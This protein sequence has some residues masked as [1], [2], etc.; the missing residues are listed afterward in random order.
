[1]IS[2]SIELSKTEIQMLLNCIESAI[3]TGHIPKDK[4]HRIKE[5]KR[6]LEKY[7]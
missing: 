5:I 3:E 7:L 6:Q 1:M 4:E 2:I